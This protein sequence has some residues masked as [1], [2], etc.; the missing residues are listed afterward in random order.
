MST[1]NI[2]VHNKIRQFPQDIPKYFLSLGNS[3]KGFNKK[4]AERRLLV[5]FKKRNQTNRLNIVQQSVKSR[6]RSEAVDG[7]GRMHHS[8]G[9]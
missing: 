1:Q 5:V 4:F 2:H 6:S 9:L 7:N 3:S 8:G